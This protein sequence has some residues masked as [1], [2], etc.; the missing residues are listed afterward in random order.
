MFST[1]RWFANFAFALTACF[2]SAETMAAEITADRSSKGTPF[3]FVV[4]DI[5][6][7]DAERF[8]E[9]AKVENAV[10]L[11]ESE[12]GLVAE[13]IEIGNAIRL[14]GFSTGVINGSVCNSSCGLIWLAGSPRGLSKSAKVGF[15]AAYAQ[16][17][18][19][20]AE[21]GVANALVG[22][23]LTLLNLPERMVTFATSPPPSEMGWI[24]ESNYSRLGIDVMVLNDFQTEPKK[25]APPPI[26]RVNTISPVAPPP[27]IAPRAQRDVSLWADLETWSVHV[28]HTLNQSCFMGSKFPNGTHLRIGY[29]GFK[30][31]PFYF[32]AYNENWSS[33]KEGQNYELT[34]TFDKAGDWDMPVT[35]VRINDGTLALAGKFSDASFLS[36]VGVSTY[37]GIKRGNSNVVT[38]NLLGSYKA[39]TSLI[40]C[41]EAQNRAIVKDPFAD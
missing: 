8:K 7:G 15:H 22:R 39:V 41:Q 16:S 40:D 13:A 34:V 17:G 23:Y 27:T 30:E 29:S 21:S 6:S 9:A 37:V 10:V 19:H 20:V 4:G 25:V 3:I 36:D 11:L 28:D 32:L 26:V 1:F 24:T 33:L 14:K 35:V 5:E 18:G 38:V 12:G 2:A 31:N